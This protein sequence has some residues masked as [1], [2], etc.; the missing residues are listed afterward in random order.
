LQVG[1]QL[2]ICGDESAEK[3]M[4]WTARNAHALIYICTGYDRPSGSLW[5]W[6]SAYRANRAGN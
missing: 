3:H 6:L 2:L 4:R 1:D 5:R